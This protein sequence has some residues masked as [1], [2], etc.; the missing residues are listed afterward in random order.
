M[1][2]RKRERGKE[3]KREWERG[4]DGVGEREVIG[5]VFI[6]QGEVFSF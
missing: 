3:E 1:G 6:Y 4:R 5:L 2:E